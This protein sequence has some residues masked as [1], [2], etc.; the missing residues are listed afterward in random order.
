MRQATILAIKQVLKWYID[1]PEK[2][3]GEDKIVLNTALNLKHLLC[4]WG[5]GNQLRSET[6]EMAF[7]FQDVGVTIVQKGVYDNEA[8]AFNN[9]I[10]RESLKQMKQ[11]AQETTEEAIKPDIKKIQTITTQ[12]YLNKWQNYFEEIP[13]TKLI[14]Q[15]FPTLNSRL[16]IQ[17][18][19]D[20]FI[21]QMLTDH[22]FSRNYLYWINKSHTYTC[23]CN[24]ETQTI[25]HVIHDCELISE[26]RTRL[27]NNIG[28]KLDQ[29]ELIEL[30][31]PKNIGAFKK[32]S[33]KV[34]KYFRQISGEGLSFTSQ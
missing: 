9:E 15:F 12:K 8:E 2:L 5:T 10:V 17:L 3:V 19:T 4:Y 23:H 22:S 1:N 34:I 20:H 6:R 31:L 14:R 21:T 30:L 11:S 16:D 27:E 29:T 18:S 26:H 7:R 32:F 25:Q 28:K 13:V 24:K 33:Q